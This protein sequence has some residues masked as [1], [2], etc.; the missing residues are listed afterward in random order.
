M[1]IDAGN[2]AVIRD[3]LPGLNL[4]FLIV[5]VN[6]KKPGSPHDSYLHD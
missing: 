5:L 4:S 3:N 2:Q 6:D 1:R